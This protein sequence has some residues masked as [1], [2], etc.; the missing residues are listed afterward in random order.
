MTISFREANNKDLSLIKSIVFDALEEYG[1]QSDAAH[2]DKDL[3]DIEVFYFE[4][5]GYFCIVETEGVPVATGGLLHLDE[6][7]CEL[8]KMYMNKGARGKGLGKQLLQHLLDWAKNN[9]YKE[10][11]LETATVLVEAIALYKK[12]GFELCADME[13]SSRCDQAMILKF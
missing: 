6:E 12:Y 11:V 4:P 9:G 8:R 3:E 1:L 13:L 5:G 7:R 10:V 2:T